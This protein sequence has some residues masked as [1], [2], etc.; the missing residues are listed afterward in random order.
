ME[1]RD[2]K[3]PTYN[4]GYLII[5]SDHAYTST[6]K[7]W[8]PI[9]AKHNRMRNQWID[10]KAV[11]FGVVVNTAPVGSPGYLT[12]VELKKMYDAG[13][14]ILSHNRYHISIGALPI[15]EQAEKGATTLKVASTNRMGLR[16]LR[17]EAG[18]GAYSYE[19]IDGDN[20]E[21]FYFSGHTSTTLFLASPLSR[22]FPAG[23]ILKPTQ[24]TIED[25]VLGCLDDLAG[26]GIDDVPGYVYPDHSASHYDPW[27]PSVDYVLSVHK[28]ARG[29][30]G[31]TNNLNTIDW[32]I[33]HGFA[34]RPNGVPAYSTID[35]ILEETAE[36]NLLAIV[37]SHGE[38]EQGVL[39]RLEY[40]I[41]KALDLG[42]KIITQ[43]QAYQMLAKK[44]N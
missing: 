42:I 32:G 27:R 17:D 12:P 20:K 36:N 10:S 37:W 9:I 21:V 44:H 5:H 40:I 15:T 39:D 16:A 1:F 33:L 29:G 19:L 38:T 25:L 18:Y 41:N 28:A 2:V 13:V 26:W 43:K 6:F 24:E 14:E 22:T 30:Y 11:N 3:M 8:L 23:S 34:L 35:R 31:E 7:T 4:K